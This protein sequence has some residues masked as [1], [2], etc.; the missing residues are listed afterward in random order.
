M[1]TILESI[2]QAISLVSKELRAVLSELK[3]ILQRNDKDSY[4][5]AID[6]IERTPVN[7]STGIF[8]S[9]NKSL[10][11][12][13]LSKNI[14]TLNEQFP[15]KFTSAPI[16]IKEAGF[17]QK[18][19]STLMLVPWEYSFSHNLQ[20][21]IENPIISEWQKHRTMEL[22]SFEIPVDTIPMHEKLHSDEYAQEMKL[23]DTLNER[24]QNDVNKN[25]L[26]SY[27]SSNQTEQT[28]E[29]RHHLYKKG[30]ITTSTAPQLGDYVRDTKIVIPETSEYLD[31]TDESV[32]TS[33]LD[34][35]ANTIKTTDTTE[36]DS[37]NKEVDQQRD[38]EIALNNLA[39]LV[40]QTNYGVDFDK[41]V[42][43]DYLLTKGSVQKLITELLKNTFEQGHCLE[44]RDGIAPTI[45]A[46]RGKH[47]L[48]INRGK[49]SFSSDINV[50]SIIYG[51]EELL[52]FDNTNQVRRLKNTDADYDEL[53]LLSKQSTNPNP[54]QLPLMT[55]NIRVDVDLQVARDGNQLKLS[56]QPRVKDFKIMSNTSLIAMPEVSLAEPKLVLRTSGPKN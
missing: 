24:F 20:D 17:L 23:F 1:P 47:T 44:P 53:F 43:L 14:A 21:D 18:L 3:I 22:I 15:S 13:L 26:N 9:T 5:Q 38:K 4:R 54:T 19:H 6:F 35:Y 56:I 29:L 55:S 27:L 52:A 32:P 16:S 30:E 10:G 48:S 40:N 12:L 37:S 34:P 45:G 11:Q 41:R 25:Q 36:V 50:Y 51:N 33:F 42:L 8:S 28:D 39:T 46:S 7:I 31:I 2:D 49:L